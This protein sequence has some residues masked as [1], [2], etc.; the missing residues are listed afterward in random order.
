MLE[1]RKAKKYRKLFN[2]ILFCK[3]LKLELGRQLKRT[4]KL[5]ILK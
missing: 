4:Q 2:I 3:H 5:R 1:K